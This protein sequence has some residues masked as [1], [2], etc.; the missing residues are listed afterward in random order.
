VDKAA[1]AE[2][3]GDKAAADTAKEAWAMVRGA[4]A[5]G[6]ARPG[7]KAGAKVE[8]GVG[9]WVSALNPAPDQLGMLKSRAKRA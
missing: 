7:R 1:E 8:A 5:A 6:S 3:A 4:W 2:V 9:A